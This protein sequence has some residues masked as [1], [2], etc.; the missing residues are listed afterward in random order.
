MFKGRLKVGTKITGGFVIVLLLTLVLVMVNLVMLG[1]VNGEVDNL[2]GDLLPNVQRLGQINTALSD[3]KRFEFEYAAAR[4]AAARKA[5]GDGME[6][7]KTQL[8]T[9]TADLDKALPSTGDGRSA[10]KDF[11]QSL[12]DYLKVHESFTALVDQNHAAQAEA[13]LQNE[14]KKA[15]DQADGDINKI[16][17]IYD[18]KS[19]DDTAQAART[20]RQAALISALIGA[21]AILAGLGIALVISRGIS[22]PVVATA[23]NALRLADGDLTIQELRVNSGD[24]IAD[25]AKAFNKMLHNLRELLGEINKTAEQVASTSEELS[26]TSNQVG[27]AVNQVSLAITGI[28]GGATEQSKSLSE[29]ASGVAQLKEAIDQIAKGAQEQARATSDASGDVQ[30]MAGAVQ[31]ISQAA[32]DLERASRAT[33]DSAR[34]GGQTV[35]AAIEGMELIRKT[36]FE[37]AERIKE[38]GRNSE[39]I[40]QIIQV[41]DEIAGQTNLLALNAAI[42]AARAGEAGRGFAVVAEEVRKLAE[43]SSRATREIG[44]LIGNMQHGTDSAVKAME[45]GMTEVEKGVGQAAEAGKALDLIFSTV[46]ETV[47]RIRAIVEAAEQASTGSTEV[48]KSVDTVAAITEE[49]TAATEQMAASSNQVAESVAKAAAVAEE[50][51]ASTEEVSASTEEMNASVEEIVASAQALAQMATN[52]QGLVT[53]FRL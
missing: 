35:R 34:T 52:L 22:V 51:A 28:A 41:I 25:L 42:E 3:L 46:D 31:R 37:T 24:E 4:D 48:V 18:K 7:V 19:D 29:T 21:I 2:S 23:R 38:L 17:A 26:A 39:Q 50:N 5:A 11:Q 32:G 53:R 40:G 44:E 9:V 8:A 49:N 20:Y 15:F 30:K 36:V 10:F 27:Q 33:A 6:Q 45:V 1:R 16:I 13:L 14:G 43:R 12:G 47:S